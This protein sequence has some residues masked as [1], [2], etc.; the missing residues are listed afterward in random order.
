VVYGQP[1]EG[2]VAVEVTT[3]KKKEIR[4]IVDSMEY[5]ASKS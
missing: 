4:K 5:V 1:C 2:M 3:Q